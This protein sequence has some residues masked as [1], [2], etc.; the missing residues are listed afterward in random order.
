MVFRVYV[1]K[2]PGFDVEA[3]QLAGELR[4]ILGP[5]GLKALRI[6]NQLPRRR[7]LPG[8]VRPDRTVFSEPQVDN[9]AYDL[10]GP[11]FAGAK[12][13]ATE[14][15]PASST[16]APIPPPN[17]SSSSPRRAPDRPLRQAV[18]AGGR[19]S[20]ADVDTIK[21]YAINPVEAREAILEP[22]ELCE[23]AGREPRARSRHRRFQRDGRR[24]RPEVH[25]RARSGHGSGR[26]RI[27]PE[28]LPARRAASPPSPKS[29]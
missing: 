21:H 17:A 9:V 26:P 16:S 1:E 4:T 20:D 7:H 24:S 11:D 8:A 14:S 18:R 25:R 27:L 2:K 6:V 10:P 3:Q 23:D 28:V 13:F 29:R 5:T 12:V 15:C 19:P 22:S